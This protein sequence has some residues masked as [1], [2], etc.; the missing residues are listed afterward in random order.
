[1]DSANSLRKAM[2]ALLTEPVRT[3]IISIPVVEI[4]ATTFCVKAV[5][6]D[7]ITVL[8]LLDT[9]QTLMMRTFSA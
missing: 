9:L 2:Q 6:I 3:V 5:H 8:D 1:M 7:P 4:K